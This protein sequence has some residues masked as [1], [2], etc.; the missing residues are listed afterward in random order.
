MV[1]LRFPAENEEAEG[2][3]KKA[4]LERTKSCRGGPG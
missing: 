3:K 4:K 1:R 2:K